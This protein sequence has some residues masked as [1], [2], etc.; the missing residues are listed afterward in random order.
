MD[1]GI[2]YVSLSNPIN[3]IYGL[4]SF[5]YFCILILST[6]V[7]VRPIIVLLCLV[8][9][10]LLSCENK[11]EDMS[12]ILGTEYFPLNSGREYIYQVDSIIFDEFNQS[13]DTITS[14][15]RI[16]Y[17]NTFIDS[18][19]T[20]SLRV[21]YD[22]PDKGYNDPKNRWV[23]V[24]KLTQ[25]SIVNY[26]DTFRTIKMSFPV[27]NGKKWDANT[28]NNLPAQIYSYKN[29]GIPFEILNFKF[30]ETATIQQYELYTP[31][32]EI[33]SYEVYAKNVGMIYSVNTYIQR[34]DGKV[35]GKKIIT[36][37]RE[38]R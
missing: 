37:L 15:L 16:R 26:S 30:S 11:K 14:R 38:Y 31:L 17:I 34:F 12:N 13:V 21:E 24:I 7:K 32:T 36:T 4:P 22:N 10:M 6:K 5:M 20:S 9:T 19:K 8:A 25:N 35:S 3:F 23:S 29:V 1:R 33:N 27:R 18:S 28:F 2:W